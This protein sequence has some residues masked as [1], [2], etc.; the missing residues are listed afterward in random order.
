MKVLLIVLI[1]MA[2]MVILPNAMAEE[3]IYHVAKVTAIINSKISFYSI[4]LI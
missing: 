1:L 4:K 2:N 3:K